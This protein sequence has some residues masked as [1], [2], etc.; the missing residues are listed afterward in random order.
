M[1]KRFCYSQSTYTFNLTKLASAGLAAFITLTTALGANALD[2]F[3]TT[4][5]RNIGNN[6]EAAFKAIFLQGDYQQ[7][8]AQTDA[9]ITYRGEN[10]AICRGHV[11]WTAS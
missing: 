8:L 3:R 4:Q 6:T 7:T 5:P 1:G 11:G 9:G 2:P 10:K